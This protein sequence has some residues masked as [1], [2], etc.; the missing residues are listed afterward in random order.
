MEVNSNLV[1]T[2]DLP[3]TQHE[4]NQCIETLCIRINNALGENISQKAVKE[5]IS[6][7]GIDTVN[8]YLNIWDKYKPFAKRGQAAYFIYCIQHQIPAPTPSQVNT[9]NQNKIPQRDNFD[10]REYTDEEYE[11]FYANLKS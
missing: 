2:V 3:S 8:Q 6:Q 9:Y 10:Q 11:S 5:I 1:N 7:Y 4:Q